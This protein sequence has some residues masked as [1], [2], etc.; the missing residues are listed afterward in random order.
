MLA[1]STRPATAPKKTP[2]KPGSGHSAQKTPPSP[3][4]T[5][6]SN[7]AAQSAATGNLADTG[8][9]DVIGWFIITA[10]VATGLRYRIVLHR[11]KTD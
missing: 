9:G 7:N 8:P 4:T 3:Q 1:N 2:A 5:T 6:S 10:I 11:L